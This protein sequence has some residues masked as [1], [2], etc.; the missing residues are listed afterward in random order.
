MMMNTAEGGKATRVGTISTRSEG[1][2]HVQREKRVNAHQK[3]LVCSEQTCRRWGEIRCPATA[4][5]SMWSTN[6]PLKYPRSY[7][8]AVLSHLSSHV[9]G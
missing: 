5:L 6:H 7:S 8:S 2:Y 9:W 4:R 3:A 1:D